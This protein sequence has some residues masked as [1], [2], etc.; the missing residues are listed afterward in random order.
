MPW[1][2]TVATVWR[3]LPCDVEQASTMVSGHT[4]I[5]VGR[6]FSTVT[7]IHR[8]FGVGIQ[9]GPRCTFWSETENLA[10]RVSA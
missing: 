4:R 3:R 8:F 1:L 5:D 9:A 2:R 7:S 10:I 6:A